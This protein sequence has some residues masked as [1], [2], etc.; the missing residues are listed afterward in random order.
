MSKQYNRWLDHIIKN[1]FKDIHGNLIE[2]G[3]FVKVVIEKPSKKPYFQSDD[4]FIYQYHICK[5]ECV[6]LNGEWR[7]M[8]VG[9][10]NFAP[11][12]KRFAY[13]EKV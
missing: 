3:D 10:V 12:I 8:L 13:L 6:L 4:M 5:V 1:G 9:K 7:Y 11:H 2:E